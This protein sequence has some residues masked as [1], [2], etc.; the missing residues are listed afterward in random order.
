MKYSK[1]PID[2]VWN[3]PH[4]SKCINW[5]GWVARKK[6][7]FGVFFLVFLPRVHCSQI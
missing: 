3:G 1:P 6:L 7:T 5:R 4:T 2:V